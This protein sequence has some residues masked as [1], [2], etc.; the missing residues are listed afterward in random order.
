MMIIM[1]VVFVDNAN[2]NDS[3]STNNEANSIS[4]RLAKSLPRNSK[5]RY[6]TVAPILAP[7]AMRPVKPLLLA[8]SMK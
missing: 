5:K 7:A 3:D 8:I 2:D 1:I 6:D 4:S